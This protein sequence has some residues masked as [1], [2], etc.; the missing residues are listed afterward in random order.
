MNVHPR[1][2]T[3]KSRSEFEY[4]AIVIHCGNKDNSTVLLVNVYHAS[5]FKSLSSDDYKNILGKLKTENHTK[6]IL[7]AGDLNAHS[8]LWDHAKTRSDTRGK[9]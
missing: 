5:Q 9:L 4:H 2:G 3:S 1:V 6:Y 8:P 7:I